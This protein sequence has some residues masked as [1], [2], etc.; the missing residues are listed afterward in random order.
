MRRSGS[1]AV[2][3]E[4]TLLQE[5]SRLFHV[6][7]ANARE[8]RITKRAE[9]AG[10]NENT[11][12]IPTTHSKQK[13]KKKNSIGT[14][15]KEKK[16]TR[17]PRRNNRGGTVWVTLKGGFSRVP[18]SSATAVVDHNKAF[19]GRLSEKRRVAALETAE[20]YVQTAWQE[21]QEAG[22]LLPDGSGPNGSD[23]FQYLRE[24]Y[25][26]AAGMLR[27]EPIGERLKQIVESTIPAG[28]VVA[29][30]TPPAAEAAPEP[31]Y[32]RDQWADIITRENVILRR[33]ATSSSL[34]TDNTDR[35]LDE[36]AQVPSRLYFTTAEPL[37]PQEFGSVALSPNSS[38]A[39]LLNSAEVKDVLPSKCIVRIRS[40]GGKKHTAILTTPK[41]VNGFKSHF[42]QILR[43]ELGNS[44]L[45]RGEVTAEGKHH[46]QHASSGGGVNTSDNAGRGQSKR[47]NKRRRK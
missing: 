30:G 24:Q 3:E 33:F 27:R 14:V 20:A 6:A 43:K 46:H 25:E 4:K 23:G 10:G 8:Q 1:R 16:L 15:R 2:Q 44:R 7:R 38:G 26:V 36:A 34:E 12:D 37:A 40:S 47:Q 32:T 41:S 11:T 17:G 28:S 9:A 39:D 18:M 21:A 13:S 5:L 19:R 42:M 29:S 22:L 31:L 35:I 45:P